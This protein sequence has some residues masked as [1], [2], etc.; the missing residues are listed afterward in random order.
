VLHW[1]Q[2]DEVR[3]YSWPEEADTP[4]LPIPLRRACDA[5]LAAVASA[6]P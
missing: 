5:A 4:A 3:E 1:R 6:R 2:G